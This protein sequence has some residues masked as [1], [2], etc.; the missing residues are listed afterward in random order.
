MAVLPLQDLDFGRRD[1][2]AEVR[3]GD[4]RA[5][6]MFMDNFI[7][8]SGLDVGEFASGRRTVILGMK[9]SGKTAL[10]I[11]LR[12]KLHELGYRTRSIVFSDEMAED[13]RVAFSNSAGYELVETS[14][15][16]ISSILQDFEVQWHWFFHRQIYHFLLD[17]PDF[18]GSSRYARL[19]K[20]LVTGPV[21]AAWTRFLPQIKRSD[22][23]IEADFGFLRAHF[24]GEFD[25]SQAGVLKAS[26]RDIVRVLDREVLEVRT[27]LARCV[28]FID[29]I[30]LSRVSGE[31]YFRDG[32]IVRDLIVTA[33]RFNTRF[34]ESGVDCKIV[35][36]VREEVISATAT[37]GKEITKLIS[38]TSF[39][40]F[41]H[42]RDSGA[43]HPLFEIISR[44]IRWLE[45]EKN[46]HEDLS[47][48][49]RYF[50]KE[51]NGANFFKFVSQLSW[52]RP[53]DFVRYFDVIR[54]FALRRRLSGRFTA[55]IMKEAA[56][57]YSRES[58]REVRE[59]LQATLTAAQI[60]GIEQVLSGLDVKF[61]DDEFDRRIDELSSKSVEVKSLRK[62]ETGEL[63][64]IFFR[65]A[66]IGNEFRQGNRIVNRWAYRGENSPI[67]DRQ[68]MVHRGLRP[69]FSLLS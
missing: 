60:D 40:L 4:L 67:L 68:F 48:F 25:F 27:A 47:V 12:T 58:W 55:E 9:G 11:Y 20:A 69:H 35:I 31:Q 38:D 10:Q 26:L 56:K 21:D 43:N 34:A 65:T 45:R 53:R 54:S 8:L 46:I 13:D 17:Q 66:V 14:G 57:E 23:K 51:V 15:K 28:I 33:H 59:E 6:R 32:R 39:Q 36:G 64:G 62:L 30:N 2:R 52:Y 22:I 63:I 44:K 29:E 19:L 3:P 50:P 37:L 7:T 61:T 41:W 49:A 24:A 5:Q 16:N 1:A 42:G 18:S